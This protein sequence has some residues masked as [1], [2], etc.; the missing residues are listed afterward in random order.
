MLL[1]STLI[2]GFAA[3]A[4]AAPAQQMT[5][6]Y[7]GH[8][9]MIDMTETFDH[10]FTALDGMVA[11]INAFKGDMAGV[12]LIVA[13]AAIVQKA[14][15]KGAAQIKASPAMTIPDIV[16]ILGPV[17]VMQSR[18][19]EIVDTLSKQKVS[20]TK[21]GGKN[22]IKAALQGE[23]DAADGL[24]NSIKANLPLPAITGPVAGPIAATIT[25][26]LVRGLKEWA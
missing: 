8:L 1:K 17:T 16:N 7:L 9:A 24:V 13:D 14:I 22:K 10:I 6:E 3:I 12:D 2:A 21:A 4:L 23:K 20:I 15:T 25:N 19:G 26:E 18:V 5:S 11:D